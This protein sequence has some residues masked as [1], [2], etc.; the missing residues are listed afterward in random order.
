MIIDLSRPTTSPRALERLQV[1]SDKLSFASVC[2]RQKGQYLAKVTDSHW[3]V[4]VFW[5]R[6]TIKSLTKSMFCLFLFRPEQLFLPA[7]FERRPT[8]VFLDN[9]PWVHPE[10]GTSSWTKKHVL[11]ETVTRCIIAGRLLRT[12]WAKHSDICLPTLDDQLA[13]T[14]A[15]LN[16]RYNVSSNTASKCLARCCTV[17]E[18]LSVRFA[19][20]E[21]RP[22]RQTQRDV[23]TFRENSR[24]HNNS[25]SKRSG[26]NA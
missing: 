5:P 26:H 21:R 25:S 24:R 22:P 15:L 4:R 23:Y 11:R 19:R 10:A 1:F 14:N 13:R 17:S 12:G 3:A 18:T 2:Q 6:V 7:K 16:K 9:N 20:F 8:G